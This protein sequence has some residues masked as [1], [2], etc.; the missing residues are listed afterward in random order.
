MW[1]RIVLWMIALGMHWRMGTT[2]GNSTSQTYLLLLRLLS[3]RSKL[4]CPWYEIP[5]QTTTSGVRS[6]CRSITHSGRQ[7]WPTLRLTRTRPSWSYNTSVMH[8]KRQLG[9]PTCWQL[10][11]CCWLAA[12]SFMTMRSKC[13]SLRADAHYFQTRITLEMFHCILADIEW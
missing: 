9:R 5:L 12:R 10:L 8:L 1:T 13:R 11:G 7:R 4:D 6:L 3:V 2:S